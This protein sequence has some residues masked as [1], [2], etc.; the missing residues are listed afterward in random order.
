MAYAP[1][2][3]VSVSVRPNEVRQPIEGFGFLVPRASGLR[4]LGGLF[5]SSLFPDRAP[6]GRAL[7]TC[8]LGG[9][10]WPEAVD[11]PDDVLVARL[12]KDLEVTLGLRG[13]F[14]LLS[15]SRWPRAVAQPSRRHQ[16]LVA[17]VRKEVARVGGLAVAGGWLDGVSIADTVSSGVRA[18][19][20]IAAGLGR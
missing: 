1:V 13:G 12:G 15:L 14:D 9:V 20:M 4:L 2:V 17:D 18:A 7:L 19:S 3:S 8:L 5:M 11:E 16:E 10:R 6:E